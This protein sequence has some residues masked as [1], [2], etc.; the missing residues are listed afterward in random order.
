MTDLHAEI[1]RLERI[2]NN[3]SKSQRERAQE[4]LAP[5]YFQRDMKKDR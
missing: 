4:E 5:L 3:G 1:A 2:I